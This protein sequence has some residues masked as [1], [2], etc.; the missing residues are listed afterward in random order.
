MWLPTRRRGGGRIKK[1]E[2]WRPVKEL[3]HLNI[4]TICGLGPEQKC[5]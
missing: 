2:G 4:F 5:R 3:R 1:D